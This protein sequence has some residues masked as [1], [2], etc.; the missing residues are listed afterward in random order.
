MRSIE[1]VKNAVRF[2]VNLVMG[3]VAVVVFLL[4]T[5]GFWVYVVYGQ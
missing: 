5:V 2:T 3:L 4:Y 1:I